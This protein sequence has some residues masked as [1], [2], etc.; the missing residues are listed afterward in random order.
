MFKDFERKRQDCPVCGKKEGAFM[1][2]TSWGHNYSCCSDSC[3]I[4]LKNKLDILHNSKEYKNLQK[5]IEE[6]QEKMEKMELKITKSQ[7]NSN[8]RFVNL[9]W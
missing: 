7:E 5:I 3:G 8:K 9:Y 2:S 4:E 1:G 6:N